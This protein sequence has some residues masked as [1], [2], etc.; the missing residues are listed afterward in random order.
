MQKIK[1]FNDAKKTF[2]R[3]A[4]SKGNIRQGL[5]VAKNKI[6][7]IY[8]PG[9]LKDL[10][11][12]QIFLN[13]FA[14]LQFPKSINKFNPG[15]KLAF[16]EN[17][18]FIWT[19]SVLSLF[20]KEISEF[21]KLKI[22]Y[23]NSFLKGNYSVSSDTLEEIEKTFGLS[24]WLISNKFQLLQTTQGLKAQK[25]YLENILS[26]KDLEQEVA[27]IAGALFYKQKN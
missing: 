3:L 24:F 14:T 2:T 10:H 1:S 15:K 26:T 8:L 12:Q 21:V 11:E 4:Y 16:S 25:D 6:D 13:A 23:E 17:K 18:E 22:V 19:A 20:K 27:F 9:I 5:G 7:G